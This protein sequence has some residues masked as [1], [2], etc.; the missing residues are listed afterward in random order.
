METEPEAPSFTPPHQ[1]DSIGNILSAPT[2]WAVLLLPEGA[3]LDPLERLERCR[4]IINQVH[5]DRCVDHRAA[6]AVRAV[7]GAFDA[8]SE[9]DGYGGTAVSTLPR[10]VPGSRWWDVGSAGDIDRWLCYVG[11]ARRT[12]QREVQSDASVL[13]QCVHDTERACEHLDRRRGFARS[14]LWPLTCCAGDRT[15]SVS[16]FL[17]RFLDL[18]LHLRALHRFCPLRGCAFGHLAELEAASS[19]AALPELW[20]RLVEERRLRDTPQLTA[21]TNTSDE[22][23][24]DSLDAYMAT[25]E[26]MLRDDSLQ[27]GVRRACGPVVQT[28]SP[29][30]QSVPKAASSLATEVLD[31]HSPSNVLNLAVG[32]SVGLPARSEDLSG[33]QTLQ[34]ELLGDLDSDGSEMDGL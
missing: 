6:A 9:V 5:P 15:G 17:A 31:K 21:L 13:M 10:T 4:R 34:E 2:P 18:M 20:K 11:N 25:V 33:R 3:S 19:E 24:V 8:L 29:L 22:T 14:R 27:R 7:A 26:E 23:C 28:P 1:Q 16:Q 30:L 12:L 32:C